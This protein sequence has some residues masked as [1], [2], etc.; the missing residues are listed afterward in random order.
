[1]PI[2][3]MLIS[4]ILVIFREFL[5]SKMIIFRIYLGE[6]WRQEGMGKVGITLGEMGLVAEVYSGPAQPYGPRSHL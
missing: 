3:S 1:M 5:Y 6:V 4:V 2:I